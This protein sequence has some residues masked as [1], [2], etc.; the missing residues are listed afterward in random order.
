MKKDVISMSLNVTPAAYISLSSVLIG[1]IPKI[2][3]KEAHLL[4]ILSIYDM[5]LFILGKIQ[6]EPPVQ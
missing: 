2:S 6:N 5:I 1:Y 3:F 4:S